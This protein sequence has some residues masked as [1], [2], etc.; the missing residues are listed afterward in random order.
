MKTFIPLEYLPEFFKEITIQYFMSPFVR[1]HLA[2]T[3]KK[4]GY[5]YTEDMVRKAYDKVKGSDR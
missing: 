1:L 2:L 3:S 5:Y 4:V